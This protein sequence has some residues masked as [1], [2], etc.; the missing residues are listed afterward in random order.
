[1]ETNISEVKSEAG[2]VGASL[3]ESGRERM[4]L[5]H[6]LERA[7]NGPLG[8]SRISWVIGGLAVILAILPL[9]G[10][11]LTNQRLIAQVLLFAAF[12]LSYDLLFG[13]TGIFSFGHALFFGVGAYS[14]A[15]VALKLGWPMWIGAGLGVIISAALGVLVGF[16]SLRVQGVFFAMVT[17]A[18]AT[19]AFSLSGKWVDLT[20]GDEGLSLIQAKDAPDTTTVY[21]LA[22]GLAVI[23]Y[24]G[25]SLV[26]SSPLGRVLVA[27]RENE[28]RAEMIG[29][30]ILLYK[31]V[32]LVFS[33]II[34]SL[35]GMIYGFRNGIVNPGVLSTDI[36]LLP[37]LMV[38]LG[39]AGTLYGAVI[40]AA[41]IECLNFVLSSR[42][43]VD[44]VKDWF[45]VGPILEHWLL[46]LGLMYALI[47]L[48][49]PY[50]L[51]GTWRLYQTRL[52]N[53]VKR[54]A[55]KNPNS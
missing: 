43:F 23:A 20:K 35:A 54:P 32:A 47:V 3:S 51:V 12:A 55:A 52:A 13:Y 39:G 6:R 48:F 27:I 15:L 45:I 36:S 2:M 37:L 29:Y 8:L 30:N 10:L 24:Y 26:I 14:V 18:L 22:L 53:L 21:F 1:M 19:T 42:E 7:G 46:L 9:L 33:A 38:I 5:A 17:L 31:I 4:S 41:I 40:G 34:A 16:V 44:S 28:R 49:L 11:P 25:L 50:G